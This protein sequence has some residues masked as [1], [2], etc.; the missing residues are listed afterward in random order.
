MST[1]QK[2]TLV[3][4]VRSAFGLT[5][6]LVALELPRSTWHYRQ[7][8]G[9]SYNDKYAHLRQ[10]LEAIARAHP[11]YGY[12]R[13][14]VELREAYGQRVNHK[15][16]RK[17]HQAWELPL[18]R[19]TRRPKPNGIRQALTALGERANLVAGRQDIQPF[20]VVY[21]DFSK[22]VYAG[23]ARK[24]YLIPL[25][26]YASQAG[27]GLGGGRTQ[28]YGAG[29]GGPGAGEADLDPAWGV[30]GGPSG[31]SRPRSR[32]HRLWLDSSTPVSRPGAAVLRTA[33]CQG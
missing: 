32:V 20:E 12:R 9:R 6:A 23:G 21:T 29:T 11:E 2:V 15:V 31:A 27:A 14:V 5:P 3:R 28:R 7:K 30:A 17:L 25:L 16:V 10:P 13:T 24:A 4:E 22:V 1:E 33:W 19:G 18:L 8:H 26:D